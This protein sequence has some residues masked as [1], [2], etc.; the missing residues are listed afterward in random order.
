MKIETNFQYFIAMIVIA[1][2]LRKGFDKLS[3]TENRHLD[4]ISRS[5][6]NWEIN[7]YR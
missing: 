5:V 2:Y 3:E 6:E 4:E 1:S 7:H